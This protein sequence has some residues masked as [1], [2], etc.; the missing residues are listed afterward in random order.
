[1]ARTFWK[2]PKR[3][4]AAAGPSSDLDEYDYDPDTEVISIPA[5][6][7]VKDSIRLFSA[8]L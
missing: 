3:L 4:K 8:L 2:L 7:M 1:V 5:I 6:T